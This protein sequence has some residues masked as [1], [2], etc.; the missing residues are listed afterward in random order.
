MNRAVFALRRGD[1]WKLYWYPAAAAR[2]WSPGDEVLVY[3]FDP[4]ATAEVVASRDRDAFLEE[5][6]RLR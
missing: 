2:N 1:S 6:R 3:R 4:I 5:T